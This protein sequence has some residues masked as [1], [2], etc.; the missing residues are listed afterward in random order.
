MSLKQPVSQ[1]RLTNI[2]IVKYRSHGKRF[3]IA[4]YRNKV[5]DWRDGKEHDINEVLQTTT[6]FA[7]VIKGD[8]VKAKQLE[9]VF[10]TSDEI[11]IC[12][13]IL[14][15]GDNQVSDKEREMFQE[16]KFRDVATLCCERVVHAS[17][18][19]Q[20]TV[21]MVMDALK[22]QHFSLNPTDSAKKQAL[23]AIVLLVRTMPESFVRANMRL[24]VT[25]QISLREQIDEK[26]KEMC[27]PFI[28]VSTEIDQA[29]DSYSVTFDCL[30]SCYRQLDQFFESLG[31][32]ARF[33]L[34]ENCVAEKDEVEIDGVLDKI[35]DLSIQDNIPKIPEPIPE[36]VPTTRQVI[37]VPADEE[38]VQAKPTG[39]S[40]A[41]CDATNIQDTFRAHCKS[42]WHNFNTKRKVKKMAPVSEDEFKELQFDEDFMNNF[43]GVD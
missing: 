27:N 3:E 35:N 29:S 32:G 6:I 25:A 11:A 39:P 13:I 7:N 28:E 21:Q 4:C 40:C 12:K 10:G 43:R 19:R 14:E 38:T 20:L 41:T 9:Q 23:K 33:Q 2:T 1:K 15:K 22:T 37:A 31:K 26:L 16:E 8:V 18:R 17:T 34:L 42:E 5:R 24:N 30:P 36:P